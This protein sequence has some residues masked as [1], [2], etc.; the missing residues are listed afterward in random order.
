MKIFGVIDLA[1]GLAVH[2]RGG[3]RNLYRPVTGVGGMNV[4]G[5]AV[6]LAS[7]YRDVFGITD[8]Y[9][10]DL[11]AI[12]GAP[13]PT[14]VVEVLRTVARTLWLDAGTGT[15]A[16]ALEAEALGVDGVVVGLESVAHLQVAGEI[17]SSLTQ[18]E[19]IF[20][21]DLREGEPVPFGD[22]SV[23]IQSDPS[24]LD[25]IVRTVWDGGITSL[26]VLDL[27]RVGSGRGAPEAAFTRV[28]RA[29]PEGAVY[30]GGG[31][32][33]VAELH[34]LEAAGAAGALVG[35]A[36]HQ[37]RLTHADLHSILNR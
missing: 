34:G 36:V 2:A 22:P 3:V 4:S 5:N 1:S 16:R 18:S 11:D 27:A 23:S 6:K 25:R 33:S 8:L 20:S 32:R 37:G 29:V 15:V 14:P 26:I 12:G 19:A 10:A 30:V 7:V 9:V 35:T 31:I 28:H 24:C 17:R 21:L 13:R